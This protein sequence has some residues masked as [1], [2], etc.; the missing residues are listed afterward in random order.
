MTKR[1]KQRPDAQPLDAQPETTAA[2][3]FFDRLLRATVVV[4]TAAGWW[5]VPRT[6]GGWQRRQR[7][8]MTKA[9]RLERLTPARDVA[10]AWLG[11]PEGGGA[12]NGCETAPPTHERPTG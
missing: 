11:I 12:E 10:P 8:T 2:A 5:L 4:E 1:T 9:A 7:L 3:V 6:A